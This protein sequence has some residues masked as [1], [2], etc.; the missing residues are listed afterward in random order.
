MKVIKRYLK[1]IN[2]SKK[3]W[4]DLAHKNRSKYKVYKVS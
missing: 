2:F 4:K 1:T 3:N